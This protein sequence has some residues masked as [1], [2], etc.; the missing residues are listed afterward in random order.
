MTDKKVESVYSIL[1]KIVNLKFYPELKDSG[2]E[3]D[4]IYRMTNLSTT[5]EHYLIVVNNI[6]IKFVT[7]RDFIHHFSNFLKHNLTALNKQYNELISIT[8]NEYTDDVAIEMKYKEVDFFRLKQTE[9]LEKLNQ[10]WKKLSD[11]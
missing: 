6:E 3:F 1:S 7:Q 5:K 11:K 9:L 2:I 8:T 10:F 4:R